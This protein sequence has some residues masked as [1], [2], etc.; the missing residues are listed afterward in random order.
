MRCPQCGSYSFDGVESCKGCGYRPKSPR[1]PTWWGGRF[2]NPRTEKP[3]GHEEDA[4][5]ASSSTGA[6]P[7]DSSRLGR[8]PICGH[9]SLQWQ[10]TRRAFK[11]V[12]SDCGRLIQADEVQKSEPNAQEESKE[13]TA[14]GQPDSDDRE[15]KPQECPDCGKKSLVH[16][17]STGLYS[18]T[19]RECRRT[20]TESELLSLRRGDIGA[21]RR[22]LRRPF[23]ATLKDRPF[24]WLLVFAIAGAICAGA[25]FAT[26]GSGEDSDVARIPAESPTP[27]HTPIPSAE[28][29]P[30]PTSNTG[31]VQTRDGDLVAGADGEPIV[32]V[33]NPDAEDPSWIDLYEFLRDDTTDKQEYDEDSFVCADFAEMLHNNAE[34][35]GLRCAYVVIR[36]GPSELYPNGASHALN[37]F[38]TTDRGMVYIDSAGIPDEETGPVGM[39]RSVDLM[40]GQLYI[41]FSFF[42]ETSG[43]LSW[44]DM[45]VAEKKLALQW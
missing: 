18:C 20:F 27:T 6:P 29:T 41:P 31:V 4:I 3:S 44:H 38:D 40:F 33:N 19:N 35:A 15:R 17:E 13:A 23:P 10:R 12:N 39:D 43:Q 22:L 34:A 36:L 30:T 16:D 2:W 1:P 7:R 28:P 5:K 8:C 26:F 21:M 32:L 25:F 11:C 45:G 42:G 9:Q 37:A 24:T 14:E